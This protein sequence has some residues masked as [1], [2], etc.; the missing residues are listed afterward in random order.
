MLEEEIKILVTLYIKSNRYDLTKRSFLEVCFVRLGF[1]EIPFWSGS[2][3]ECRQTT[4]S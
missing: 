2:G 1:W 3:R 4:G